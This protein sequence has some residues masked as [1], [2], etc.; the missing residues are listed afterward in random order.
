MTIAKKKYMRRKIAQAIGHQMKSIDCLIEV[1]EFFDE[2][3]PEWA[4]LFN[5]IA[6]NSLITISFIKSLAIHAWG[7]FP[8]NLN[9]WL[10]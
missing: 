3:H 2:F 8:D 4:E 6:N 10:K 9:T 5:G 1:R 7:F